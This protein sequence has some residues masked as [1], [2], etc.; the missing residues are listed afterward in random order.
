ML[1]DLTTGC[2]FFNRG[3]ISP[4]V[5]RD[6]PRDPPSLDAVAATVESA[7]GWTVTT[8]TPFDEGLNGVYRIDRANDDPVV[9][10]AASF[11]TDDE[12][13]TEA[14]L[15]ERIGAASAVP[16]PAVNATLDAAGTDFGVAAFVMEHC[17]GRVEPDLLE[18]PPDARG[19]L[20]AESGHHL[21]RSHAVRVT[22]EFG[23]LTLRDGAVASVESYEEWT[24]W[25]ATFA[26][27]VGDALLG[28]GATTDDEPRFA[29]LAPAVE[30]ALT[31]A[32][33]A[34]GWT[35]EPSL[36]FGDYRPANLVLAPTD[37][38]DP[39]VRA[40]VDVGVGPTA[41]GL[42]DLALA[43]DAMVDVPLG[44]TQAADRLRERLR[45]AYAERRGLDPAAFESDRYACY[46]LY[47]RAR[48]L[49]GFDYWATFAR[50]ADVD[51][52]AAR[53]RSFVA[54]RLAELE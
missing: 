52:V 21:A 36:M 29:D 16:V 13:L 4:V 45:G 23:Q 33:D 43:E 44:G 5:V 22:D 34:G 10:K 47:A 53:W 42:L 35:A 41:D 25:F 24:T 38:A 49:A 39:L 12:L 31:E 28:E 9:L 26:E 18:L 7:L 17:E 20:V 15:F 40:V 50:E 54:D 46:R 2:D 14:A 32:V 8:V 48:R 11:V 30:R 51:A 6:E 3:P 37:D 19:R 1:P 27:F